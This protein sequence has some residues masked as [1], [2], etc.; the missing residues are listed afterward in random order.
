MSSYDTE[1]ARA[2]LEAA[3]DPPVEPVEQAQPEST[4]VPSG[5]DA[6]SNSAEKPGLFHGVDPNALT[7]EMRE[8]F[9]SMQRDYTQKAQELAAQRK[10]VESLG[11][12][13]QVRNAVE[14][15]QALRDPQNLV[16]LHTELTDYL[17]EL[18]LSKA[19]AEQV[20]ATQTGLE[21]EDGTET[22]WNYTDPDAESVRRELDDLRQWKEQLEAE[23]TQSQIEAV[24]AQQETAIRQ[25]NP[26]YKEEDIQAIYELSYAYGADLVSAQKA[27]ESHRQRILSSYVDTKTAVPAA[28]TSP[29]ATGGS[30]IPES[31]PSLKE[32]HEYAKRRAM[33]ELEGL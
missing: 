16:Q 29:T 4:E 27:Y 23:R 1:A 32:A 30:Q 31:F 12:F 11:D 28:L 9:D 18:G 14:F 8:M 20:A 5:V 21:T 2:A 17:Q 6:E 25:T 7:P 10:E 15:A 3:I 13:D 24:L 26:T 22:D 19:E 33:V